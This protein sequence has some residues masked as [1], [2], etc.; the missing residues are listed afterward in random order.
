VERKV[1]K[2]GRKMNFISFRFDG[3]SRGPN[4]PSVDVKNEWIYTSTNLYAF[5]S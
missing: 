1:R 2:N 4:P 3:F 5:I